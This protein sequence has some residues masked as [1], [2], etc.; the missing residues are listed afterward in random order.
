MRQ[1]DQELTLGFPRITPNLVRVNRFV[2]TGAARGDGAM[3][4]APPSPPHLHDL[5]GTRSAENPRSLK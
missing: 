5:P 1:A 4:P 2:G 3:A